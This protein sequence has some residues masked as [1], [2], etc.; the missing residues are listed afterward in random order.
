MDSWLSLLLVPMG[1]CT[2]H[3]GSAWVS[4]H[5]AGS[6]RRFMSLVVDTMRDAKVSVGWGPG[7]HA[8]HRV[9]Y[10]TKTPGGMPREN[11]VL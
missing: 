10:K 1:N 5:L 3:S 11:L 9:Y 8:Y 4:P 2:L 6:H 7:L